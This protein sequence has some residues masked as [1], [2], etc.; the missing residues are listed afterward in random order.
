KII[1]EKYLKPQNG[2]LNDYKIYCFNGIPKIVLV[3]NHNKHGD[4]KLFYDV[5][6]KRLDI[7]R[8]KKSINKE[9]SKPL[10]FEKMLQYSKKLAKPFPFV[11]IDFYD[12]NNKA[13]LSE[14]TFTPAACSGTTSN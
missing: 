3:I 4:E 7:N 12:Y 1:C 6:W 11:R 5:E 13:I 2:S 10:S 9:L 14:L 8:N